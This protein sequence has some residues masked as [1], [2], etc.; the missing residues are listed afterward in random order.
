M[1]EFFGAFPRGSAEVIALLDRT[2]NAYVA[3]GKAGI[4]TPLYCF[5]ARRPVD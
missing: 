4:F 3:G 2:G 1:A 5:V